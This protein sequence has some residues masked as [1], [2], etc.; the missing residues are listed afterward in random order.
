[1]RRMARVDR[2][3]RGL[4]RAQGV[5]ACKKLE[6]LSVDLPMLLGL[7]VAGSAGEQCRVG[8]GLVERRDAICPL[9]RQG[10]A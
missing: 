7:E 10:V 6:D 9:N 5:A 2:M 1:M 4:G 3:K 8:S